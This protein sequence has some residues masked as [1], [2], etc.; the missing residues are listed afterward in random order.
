M[1]LSVFFTRPF[2]YFLCAGLPRVPVGLTALPSW[3]RYRFTQVSLGNGLLLRF[4]RTQATVATSSCE[5]ELLAACSTAAEALFIQS[6]F[7][8]C[9]IDLKIEV[10]MDSSAALAVTQRT[11][12]GKLRHVD[13]KFL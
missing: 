13:V 6:C 2:I 1:S 10:H 7:R 8:E 12:L 9:K 11:G 3:K 4:S 5:A